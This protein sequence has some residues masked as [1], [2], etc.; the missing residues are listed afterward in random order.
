MIV[1]MRA[2]GPKISVFLFT[3]LSVVSIVGAFMYLIE[4]EANGFTS[5][6]RSIYWAIVTLTTVG[7]GDIAPSTILGQIV[8]CV[9]MILG[10][11]IIAVPTGIVSVEMHKASKQ[12][13][14]FVNCY[15]CGA[16]EHQERSKYC[17]KCG[18]KLTAL[19]LRDEDI[20]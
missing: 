2:S 3:V 8:A 1:A 10:Y 17:Y 14:E 19:Q 20:I 4:G 7:Y 16:R 9:V 5:I 6:P 15:N 12:L 13:T 18:N 11:G